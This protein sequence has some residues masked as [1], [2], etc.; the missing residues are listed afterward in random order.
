MEQENIII[1]HITEGQAEA[2]AK[3][4]NKNIN[5]LEEYEICELLD[6]IIDHLA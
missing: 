6:E 2:I 5:E 3:H 4:F 1:F